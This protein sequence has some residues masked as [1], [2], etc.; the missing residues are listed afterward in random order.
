MTIF[1]IGILYLGSGRNRDEFDHM[2]PSGIFMTFVSQM[3]SPFLVGE[4]SM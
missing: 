2:R 3:T 4:P 1:I